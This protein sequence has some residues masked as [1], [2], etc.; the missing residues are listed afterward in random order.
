M[1]KIFILLLSII[2]IFS[3]CTST[4]TEV[5]EEVPAIATPA[6]APVEQAVPEAAVEAAVAGAKM[7]WGALE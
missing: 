3:S 4:K 1:K 6:P 5:V 7:T 2:L